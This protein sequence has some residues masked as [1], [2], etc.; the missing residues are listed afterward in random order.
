MAMQA[1]QPA[2]PLNVSH[3]EVW[4]AGGCFWGVQAFLDQLKGVVY[5]NVGYANGNTENPTYEEVVYKKTGHAETVYVQYDPETISLLTLLAYFLKI[6]DPTSINRQGNDSGIQYRTGVY[7]SN[8]E[9]KAVIEA[10]LKQEQSK[11]RRP[12]A[13]EVLLLTNYYPAEEYHQKYLIKNPNGY[14]HVDLSLL[15]NDSM[16]K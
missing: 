14:C 8:Q 10:V 7:Y 1:S 4:L 9:D 16:I 15:S 3:R 11:Y 2:P 5:T 12:I 13:V 6:I